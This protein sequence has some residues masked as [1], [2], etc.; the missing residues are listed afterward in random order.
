MTRSVSRMDARKNKTQRMT[1]TDDLH[2]RRDA[3]YDSILGSGLFV[4]PAFAE[5]LANTVLPLI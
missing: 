5:L 3:T 4:P 1:T 2:Q